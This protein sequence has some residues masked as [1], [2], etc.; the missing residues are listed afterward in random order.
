[1]HQSVKL[2]DAIWLLHLVICSP[3]IHALGDASQAP[4]GFEPGSPA[5]EADDLPTELSFPP[6]YS[7]YVDVCYTKTIKM[8][9]L[10]YDK[11]DVWQCL[12]M[13]L[14]FWSVIF[15]SWF[16]ASK[17]II[18]LKWLFFL[19][20]TCTQATFDWMSMINIGDLQHFVILQPFWAKYMNISWFFVH[21]RVKNYQND[22]GLDKGDHNGF[23][24]P[25]FYLCSDKTMYQVWSTNK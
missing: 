2:T 7:Q 12:T 20:L 6:L 5:W 14:F 25:H 24:S 8:I 3:L 1:M 10:M 11:I 22:Y 4:P 9:K 23:I 19:Y 18:N 21:L 16:Y 13:I 17:L 15:M